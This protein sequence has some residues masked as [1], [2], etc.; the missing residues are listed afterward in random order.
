MEKL[1]LSCYLPIVLVTFLGDLVYLYG[2]RFISK[3][4]FTIILVGQLSGPSGLAYINSGDS[5]QD[6]GLFSKCHPTY[7]LLVTS[8][9]PYP[10]SFLPIQLIIPVASHWLIFA[11]TLKVS[12]AHEMLSRSLAPKAVGSLSTHS[13][14]WGCVL[15]TWIHATC[16]LGHKPQLTT[17]DV[18]Q[19]ECLTVGICL[20]IFVLSSQTS[21][22]FG[23]T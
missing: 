20:C 2:L 9:L 3:Q 23:V 16:S 22:S 15:V 11:Q 19:L 1:H 17:P 12:F 10:S 21:L 5:C 14:S 6:A 8:L 7:R 13:C 4:G 18:P